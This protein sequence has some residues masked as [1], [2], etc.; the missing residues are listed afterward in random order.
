VNEDEW[1]AADC[2]PEELLAVYMSTTGCTREEATGESEG[3][4][5]ELASEELDRL[6]YDYTS[7]GRTGKVSFRVHLAK[8]VAEGQTF[9]C[10]F[11]STEW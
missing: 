9:P 2:S 1:W 6:Q 4:P 7:E 8:L 10:L 11:A 3:L 5:R